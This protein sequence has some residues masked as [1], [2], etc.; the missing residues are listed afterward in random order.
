MAERLSRRGLFKAAAWVGAAAAVAGADVAFARRIGQ[1]K[2][3]LN[4]DVM[5][6]LGIQA[7]ILAPHISFR[8]FELAKSLGA[9]GYNLIPKPKGFAHMLLTMAYYEDG[10]KGADRAVQAVINR[11]LEIVLGKTTTPR[12][13]GEVVNPLLT[14]ND[15]YRITVEPAY[16]FS[17]LF[18]LSHEMYHIHQ[19]IRDGEGKSILINSPLSAGA[20]LLIHTLTGYLLDKENVLSR[21][22]FLSGALKL[23]IATGIFIENFT[24]FS[25]L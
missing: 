7:E 18:P 1:E 10:Q 6:T 5:E 8:G 4:P 25:S 20:F 14:P 23:G 13:I 15:P 19:Y 11:G 24:V 2:H 9:S 3:E 12:A 17:S 22:R 16:L 21:R